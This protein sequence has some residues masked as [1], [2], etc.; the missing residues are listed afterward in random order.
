MSIDAEEGVPDVGIP[1]GS[2]VE[3]PASICE[4]G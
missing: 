3:H 1:A 4:R 2:G